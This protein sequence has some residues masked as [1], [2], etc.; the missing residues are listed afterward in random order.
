MNIGKGFESAYN[1]A[2]NYILLG[3]IEK[4]V[5]HLYW[6]LRQSDNKHWEEGKERVF[7]AEEQCEQ[8]A[9]R[10][11]EWQVV[12][13]LSNVE[14]LRKIMENENRIVIS[15]QILKSYRLEEVV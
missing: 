5:C 1:G 9:R 11:M 6:A 7:L 12:Q 10:V 3:K 14:Y 2:A 13:C 15:G 8:W 4:G